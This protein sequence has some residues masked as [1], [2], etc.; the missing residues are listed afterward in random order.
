ARAGG[1]SVGGR[2]RTR[3]SAAGRAARLLDALAGV[4]DELVGELLAL[5]QTV[6][7][8]D[9][10]AANVLLCANAG[11]GAGP[12]RVAPV[13]WELAGAGPG[14][15]DLAML[16]S[17]RWTPTER[18]RMVAA[19]AGAAGVPPFTERQF[20]LARLHVALRWLGWAPPGWAAPPAQR[21]DWH[22]D[23]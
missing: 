11:P 5:P 8:G 19:Y 12:G 18:E 10:N 17:G 16:T 7:H 1:G 23:V 9:F 6:V 14:L 13:D 20:A 22:G 3:A 15:V 21:H 2:G 4:H